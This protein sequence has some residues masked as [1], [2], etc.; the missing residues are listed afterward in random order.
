MRY[1][2]GSETE[3]LSFAE[4]GTR[5]ELVGLH[6]PWT[7]PRRRTAPAVCWRTRYAARRC[8]RGR[9]GSSTRTMRNAHT[10]SAW[11]YLSQ[12]DAAVSIRRRRR[13]RSV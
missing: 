9:I 13:A 12:E 3:L 11:I 1:L 2:L 8:A 7:P 4:H 6:M 10:T 5:I